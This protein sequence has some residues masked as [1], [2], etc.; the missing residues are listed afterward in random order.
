VNS[1]GGGA[2]RRESAKKDDDQEW[3]TRQEQQIDL[4]WSHVEILQQN[5]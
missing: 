4:L 1:V 2:A 3:K 5:F